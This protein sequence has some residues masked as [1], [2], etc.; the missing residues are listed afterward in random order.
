MTKAMTQDDKCEHGVP[1]AFL[2]CRE[3]SIV[4]HEEGKREAQERVEHHQRCLLAL[5]A[6]QRE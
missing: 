1:M 5:T 4:W 3:C 6:G 2:Y